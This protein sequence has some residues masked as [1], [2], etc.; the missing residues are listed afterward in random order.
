MDFGE[1]MTKC[2]LDCQKIRDAHRKSLKYRAKN[3]SLHRQ[4]KRADCAPLMNKPELKI[5]GWDESDV[6]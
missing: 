6:Y 5:K 2:E 3:R 1:F 4:H